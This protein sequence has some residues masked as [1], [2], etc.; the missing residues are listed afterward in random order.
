MT[1]TSKISSL[2]PAGIPGQALPLSSLAS[3]GHVFAPSDKL[4]PPLPPPTSAVSDAADTSAGSTTHFSVSYAP[5]LG[6]SGLTIANAILA[7]CESDYNALRAWFNVTPSG[8]PFQIDVVPGSGGASH[9]GC[10]ATG[11]SIQANSGPGVDLPFLR[12]LVVAEEDEVFMGT[13]PR[14]WNCGYSNGEGLSRVLANTLYPG[15]EPSNFVSSPTW[16]N[17]NPRPDFVNTTD[18]T[19]RNYTSIG[20][21]VL[22]LYWM[23]YQLGFTWNQICQADGATLAATYTKLTGRSDALPRFEALLSARYPIG[24]PSG[25][26]TDN[27]YPLKRATDSGCFVQG[28]FG[29]VG[30]FETVTPRSN[31]GLGAFYRDNDAPSLPWHG[32]AAFG[33]NTLYAEPV[34]VFQSS[35]G[36]PGNLELVAR[37]GNQLHA[38]WRDS[39]PAFTWHGPLTIAGGVSGN[40]AMIQGRYGKIGNFEL[41][42]PLASGGL[43]ALWRDNDAPSLPWH[44]G[45][46]FGAGVYDAVA[47]IESNYGNPGNLEV[48][49]RQGDKLFAF[50]RDS[51]PS[52]TWRGPVQ[53][54]S[55]AAGTPS[56]VQGRFGNQGNFEL[57]VPKAGGGIISYWRDNDAPGLP[58]HAAASFGAGNYS[59]ASLIQSKYG[60]PG[61]LEVLARQGSQLHAYWRDSGPTYTWHGPVIAATGL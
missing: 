34:S 4:P 24:K 8:L 47:L 35:Y 1:T 17:T 46:V 50:W 37:T 26:T 38:Y 57:V 27:P 28:I 22:F 11:L 41:I 58:W 60:W 20:C 52:Y 21:A 14:S 31:G 30:N 12:S 23:R 45:P 3:A 44:T 16:L 32:P 25:L 39:G 33:G 61:N 29:G 55:G 40:P 7:T 48:V 54:A 59:S 36:I 10:A 19:D 18:P 56:F 9:A 6:A 51:G 49:A 42:A 13:S 15:A 2:P 5:S 53:F 43:C